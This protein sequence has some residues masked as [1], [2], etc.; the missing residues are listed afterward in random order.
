MSRIL[1]VVFI[2]LLAGQRSWEVR[3]SRRYE[4][5]ILAQGGRE[6]RPDHFRVM[7]LLHTSWFVM[8]V[9]EVFWK[10]RPFKPIL[11]IVA[12]LLFL[13]G[14][15]LRYAAIHTLRD[16]WTVRV[17]TLPG[18]PPVTQG[19][20][21]YLPHPNYLGVALEIAAVPLLHTAYL[22]SFAFSLANTLLLAF[23]IRIEEQ[24]LEADNEYGRFFPRSAVRRLY[25][26]PLSVESPL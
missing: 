22:T 6:Y 11:A 24:A 3:L 4:A 17:M 18:V 16:R 5:Q 19:V 9:V 20:Y 7:Q 25:F 10:R 15:T 8:M 21:R 23:R 1:F 13:L 14:Q 2:A 12:L 26:F